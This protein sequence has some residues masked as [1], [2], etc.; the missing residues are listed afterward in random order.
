M[1]A[2]LDASGRL[3]GAGDVVVNKQPKKV[4]AF[5]CP[6]RCDAGGTDNDGGH[7]FDVPVEH[8]NFSGAKCR[9]CG[10]LNMDYHMMVLP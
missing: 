7:V 2:A 3:D 5:M 9:A 10:L 6:P 1:Q 8:D 4:T